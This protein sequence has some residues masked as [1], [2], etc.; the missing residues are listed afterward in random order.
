LFIGYHLSA[1]D[2]RIVQ[3]AEHLPP[4]HLGDL[5]ARVKKNKGGQPKKNRLTRETG[6]SPTLAD[7]GIKKNTS[8]QAQKIAALP[9]DKVEEVFQAAR[10][11]SVAA[12]N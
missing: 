11:K 8:S 12:C 3:H 5:L 7:M 10:G 4:R 1:S 6:T 9:A 2:P